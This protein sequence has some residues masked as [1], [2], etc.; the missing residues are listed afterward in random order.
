MNLSKRDFLQVL[1]AASAAGMGLARYADADAATAQRGLYDVAPFGNVSFLHMTDC[2]AQL[3]PCYFR[4]PSVNIGVG[5]MRGRLPHLVGEALLTTAGLRPGTAA[6]HA[7][8]YIDFE[9]AAR[10]Y[11]RVGGFAHLATLVK[12][13]KASR[14]GALLLD[15]GDT[16]QGSATSL[17]TDAQDMVDA[18]KLLG[19]DVMTGHWEFTYGMERVKEIVEKDFN[20]RIEFLAQNVKTADFGDPVFKPYVLREINGVRCAIVGQAFPYTPI[21]NPRYLMS[22]WSFGIQDDN[23]QTV[24]DEARAK[25]AQ[26]VVLLSH[27]GMDVDLK[28]ASRVRGVDAIFGGHTHDGVPVAVPVANAG[29]KTLVT[30]AGSNGKFLGVM[31]FDVKGGRVV[32]FR[33][34][35]LPIFA[36]QLKADPEMDALITKVRAPYE[37]KLAEKLAVTDGLLYRRGNFNGSWDQLICDALMDTQDAQIAFSPGFRWGTS[38]LPG[39]VITRELMMDQVAITYPYATLNEMSGETIKTVL[40][41][42]ADNLF[43]PDPYYQ[44]GGD[45]VRVGGLAY[46][47]D[48]AQKM[49]SRIS[50]MRLDGKPLEA[51]KTYKVAGWAPVA[52]EAKNLPGVK[53]VWEHVETWLK[54][55]GGRVAPRRLN[56][57]R[58]VGLHGNP[59]IAD[60]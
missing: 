29:G 42:V 11:G 52:E 21:A 12:Q 6:A 37:S 28:M 51:G 17:W 20:G 39:D 35:L 46:T 40:E 34:R 25:G 48:P 13:L 8:T 38:L 4:E 56:T 36:N 53:P 41:D 27:N 3:K 58:L 23:M 19:V 55:Q 15:G 49:G 33:Y 50:D 31:D 45:M 1:G 32:D 22:D 59:G 44:Q 16:W 24:V 54:A 30:N 47:C 18:A 26:V 60:A 14:P 57:P 5:P 43:N 2:H 7:Y 9:K 10:R